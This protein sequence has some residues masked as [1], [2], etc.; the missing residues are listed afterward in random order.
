MVNPT[1]PAHIT[2]TRV[3]QTFP[4]WPSQL[5]VDPFMTHQ[6]PH[7]PPSPRFNPAASHHTNPKIRRVRG[8]PLQA[9]NTEG[10]TQT[11]LGLADA[12]Q[13]S[14]KMIATLPAAQ[15]ILP[16]MDGSR[17]V[18]E[19]V[20]A[21]GRGLNR[22]FLE[23]LIAQLDD[24]GL[25][26][27]PTFTAL[28]EK[29]KAD[30]DSSENLPPGSTAQFADALVV[31]AIGQEATEAQRDELGPT[32]VREMFDRWIDEAL[33]SAHDPAFD[34]LPKA[35]MA[36]HV[37][38]GRGWQNYA[39]VYGRLRTVDRPDRVVIMGTNHFGFSSGVCGCDK[40]LTTPLGVCPLD[41]PLFDAIVQHLGPQGAERYLRHKYDHER[42]HSI[43]LHIPWIQHCIG[44]DE[45]GGYVPVVAALIHD[46][47]VN[48]GASYDGQGLDLDPFVD[49]LRAAIG[50][51]GGR[52]LIV[53]S[54]DLSHCGPTFGD[55]QPLAGDSPAAAGARDRVLKH[56]REMLKL[57]A[58]GKPDDLVA[59][60]SWQQNPTRWCSIGN[61]VAT[62][63][64]TAATDIRLLSYAGAMDPQGLSFVSHAAAAMF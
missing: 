9:K 24:A 54:A 28:Y 23:Q 13:I 31:Q 58:E 41:R 2:E 40:G 15:L 44:P 42:E 33:K 5:K 18:D 14:D 1:I 30:F 52:T 3:T 32:K 27:G 43:E 34:T 10:Q 6:E 17:G 48:A 45:A 55:Q 49:A 47:T 4:G 21:V 37:D 39:G 22:G 35:I 61:I 51:V 8:F 63:R 25:L 7:Q 50:S 57:V 59:S 38:Y 19:I 62:M 26:E 36:P 64:V 53:S 29:V 46:P 16:L 20:T 56:D 60:M 12:Q 11:M